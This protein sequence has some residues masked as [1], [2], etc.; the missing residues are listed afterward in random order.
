ML[1]VVMDSP[2]SNEDF[3]GRL[4]HQGEFHVFHMSGREISINGNLFIKMKPM[5]VFMRSLS[6]DN[7]S[8][9]DKII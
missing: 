9:Y 1:S 6:S 7:E 2:D 3:A 8:R 4:L 5:F